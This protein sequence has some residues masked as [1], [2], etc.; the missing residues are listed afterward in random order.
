M[1]I[2]LSDSIPDQVSIPVANGEEHGSTSNAL[3]SHPERLQS[4]AA[5]PSIDMTSLSNALEEVAAGRNNR[6]SPLLDLASPS[7]INLSPGRRSA[8]SRRSGSQTNLLKHDVRGETPANDRYNL[9]AVQ[10]ALR[11]TKGL[12]SEVAHV[13]GSS[14]LHNEP[15]S[16]MVRLHRQAENLAKFECPPTR[17]VGFVGDSGAGK[18]AIPKLNWQLELNLLNVGKTSLINSL[19]DYQDLAMAVSFP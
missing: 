11:D 9:P 4:P 2:A 14:T 8:R 5:E 1:L 18:A 12:M 19:L 17:I 10:Q 15:D 3:S 16:V 13:L 6:S 7:P